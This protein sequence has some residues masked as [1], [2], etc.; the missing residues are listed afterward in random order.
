MNLLH[1]LA[2][3]GFIC[4]NKHI[5]KLLGLEE[6]VLLGELVS[7]YTYNENKDTLEDG[8]FYATIEKIENNTG[9]SAYKQQ[10][11]INRLCEIGILKQK[12]IGM[13]RKR[14]LTFD[15]Q[16]LLEILTTSE[17]V[18]FPKIHKQV[19]EN[20]QACTPKIHKQ[21]SE[22]SQTIYIYNNT[23]NNTDNTQV[24][25]ISN[26]KDT[27]KILENKKV[28]SKRKISAPKPPA[29]CQLPNK[30]K[31]KLMSLKLETA[32]IESIKAY[33]LYLMDSYNFKDTALCKRIDDIC[34]RGRNYTGAIQ[35]ICN[36]NIDRNYKNLY[37]PYDLS[38]TVAQQVA[39]S[40][41]A[42]EN[43]F[44]RDENG[45]IEEIW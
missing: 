39:I 19:S 34:N 32:C 36:Y 10:Q 17:L 33:C 22:N 41:Q 20:S 13:P 21:V 15:E 30:V 12:L 3:D 8:W 44:V 2:N 4:V 5:I 24:G 35:A 18:Q 31:A 29:G 11:T 16:K 42:T 25:E 7:I 37:L 26:K 27:T 23:N 14:Y 40:E 6:A 28:I 43:D 9:L 1:L 38:S 45:N